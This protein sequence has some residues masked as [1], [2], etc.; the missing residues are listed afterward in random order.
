MEL[1]I[2]HVIITS[3]TDNSNNLYFFSTPFHEKVSNPG[4]RFG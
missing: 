3:L 4:I 1:G 2:P